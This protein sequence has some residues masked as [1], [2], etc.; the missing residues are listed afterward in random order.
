MARGKPFDG[1]LDLELIATPPDQSQV[2]DGFVLVSA[3][4]PLEEGHPF[5]GV[6]V[7]GFEN[8]ITIKGVPGMVRA[9][10]S[11]N[12]CQ[13]CPG[14][15]FAPEGSAAQPQ[16]DLVRKED[17]PRLLR[18]IKPRMASEAPIKIPTA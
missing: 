15:R 12:D 3:I 16:Q 5:E 17:L 7:R 14:K 8:A 2:A 18:T 6:R 13:T 9:T 10:T 4:L 11:V 1:I